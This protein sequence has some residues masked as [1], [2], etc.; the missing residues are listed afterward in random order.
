MLEASPRSSTSGQCVVPRMKSAAAPGVRGSAGA[1]FYCMNAPIIKLELWQIIHAQQNGWLWPFH[2]DGPS[3]FGAHWIISGIGY[4]LRKPWRRWWKVVRPAAY[5]HDWEFY[6]G[7]LCG[8]SF[9]QSNTDFES[10]LS[11]FPWL[12]QKYRRAV[13]QG[14]GPDT[15]FPWRWR[16]GWTPKLVKFVE[17]HGRYPSELTAP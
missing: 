1:A 3:D 6:L 13:D 9:E 14:G 5:D 8:K 4:V 2:P 12:Q 15:P 11:E 10:K 16:F 17:K 7:E